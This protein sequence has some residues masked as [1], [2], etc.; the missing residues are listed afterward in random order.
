MAEFRYT[1]AGE[2]ATIIVDEERDLARLAAEAKR[3]IVTSLE[4]KGMAVDPHDMQYM[5]SRI[6]VAITR[7]LI[8][9]E[10]IDLGE[11]KVTGM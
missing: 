5:Q 11:I 1:I 6:A 7:D 9:K 8:S 10:F 3:T 2:S 4:E